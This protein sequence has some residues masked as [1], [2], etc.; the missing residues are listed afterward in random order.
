CEI[1]AVLVHQ[2]RS[3]PP[4]SS[5][6]ALGE[7]TVDVGFPEGI[8]G[9]PR[10]QVPTGSGP[11][12][13]FKYLCTTDRVRLHPPFEHLFAIYPRELHFSKLLHGRVS[14]SSKWLGL[15]RKA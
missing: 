9:S 15:T 5:H 3:P 4:R 10:R 2:N 1:Q 14:G 7:T 6:A 11:A 13:C 12:Y 8:C